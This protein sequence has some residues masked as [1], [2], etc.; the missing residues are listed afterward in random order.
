MMFPFARLWEW[1]VLSQMIVD[2]GFLMHGCS[3]EVSRV[4]PTITMEQ[5][6]KIST[7]QLF[8]K[9]MLMKEQMYTTES[10][11][12]QMYIF[13]FWLFFPL[14]TQKVKLVILHTF[15][16]SFWAIAIHCKNLLILY[17]LKH[18]LDC[19]KWHF[20]KWTFPKENISDFIT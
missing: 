5:Q 9:H 15:I 4:R 3:H 7:Y 11:F 6:W 13:S 8:N 12:F 14:N 10:S 18:W 17:I 16:G 20:S 19:S 1:R 2:F